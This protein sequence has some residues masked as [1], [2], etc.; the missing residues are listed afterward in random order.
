MEWKKQTLPHQ[1]DKWRCIVRNTVSPIHI[2][3]FILQEVWKAF[4]V[5]INAWNITAVLYSNGDR[6]S[7]LSPFSWRFFLIHLKVYEM[8]PACYLLLCNWT[9]SITCTHCN[10]ISLEHDSILW[11]AKYQ[12]INVDATTFHILWYFFYNHQNL[13]QISLNWI[14]TFGCQKTTKYGQI[15]FYE[16][17]KNDLANSKETSFN[18]A[19]SS[20][21]SLITVLFEDLFE[22]VNI[23]A[24]LC[25]VKE[26]PKPS[27]TSF[28]KC[29]Y[30][31]CARS[32]VGRRCL[33][34]FV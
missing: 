19:I 5:T 33:I 14:L 16:A 30:A 3:E 27:I 15:M 31:K 10:V 18:N 12:R 32:I 20:T 28:N 24:V 17:V 8:L 23:Q 1:W 29:C 21:L 22:A 13:F 26:D 34:F 25:G 2:H 6:T 4:N 7:W 11:Q 9:N